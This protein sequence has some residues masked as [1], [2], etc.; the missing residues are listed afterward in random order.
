MSK[1]LR[2]Q[3]QLQLS[4]RRAADLI[5][6]ARLLEFG[7]SETACAMFAELVRDLLMMSYHEGAIAVIDTINKKA[8]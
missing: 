6:S 7:V 3:Y 2:E 8:S 5:T 1:A 4:T